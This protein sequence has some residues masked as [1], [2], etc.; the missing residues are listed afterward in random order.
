MRKLNAGNRALPSTNR[1]M[2]ASGSICSSDQIPTSFGVMRPSG[3]TAVASTM[4]SPAPPAARLPR[5]TR[6]QSLAKPFSAEY[7]HMGETAIRLRNVTPR[8]FSGLRRST[9]G[10]PKSCRVSARPERMAFCGFGSRSVMVRSPSLQLF[11]ERR[12]TMTSWPSGD[13]KYDMGSE[14]RQ[15]IDIILF[16]GR[17]PP[18]FGITSLFAQPNIPN[19]QV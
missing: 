7:W 6:C 3:T 5:C 8:S 2:R 18:N 10:T 15:P 9:S 11:S 4:T 1:A 16:V 14:Q 17:I 13:R 19:A 12:R